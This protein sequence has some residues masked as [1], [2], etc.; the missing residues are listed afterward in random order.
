M[1]EGYGD[2]S[3]AIDSAAST[4]DQHVRG[5]E[6]A[7]DLGARAAIS[8]TAAAG[9]GFVGG[10]GGSFVM[11]GPG[12]VGGA[13]LVGGAAA[14]G[15]ERAYEGS[16]VQQWSKAL[17]RG[18]GEISYDH[19]S[20]EG[21][22][23]G[24]LNGLK[25]ALAEASSPA[26]R[27]RLQTE[28]GTVGEAFK[29]EADKNNAYFDGRG[30][31]EQGWEA[32][33]A[34]FPQLDKGDVVKAYEARLEAGKAPAE[35]VRAGYSDAVHDRVQP[36]GLPYVPEA[37]YGAYDN[38]AL[39]AAWTRYS[40]EV[41][42][43]QKGLKALEARG[44]EAS[45]M[46][47]V[48]G[49][50]SERSHHTALEAQRDEQWRDQGHVSAI[51]AEMRARGGMAPPGRSAERA[52]RAACGRQQCYRDALPAFV[53]AVTD[54]AGRQRKAGAPGRQHPRLAVGQGAGQHRVFGG[55]L[56]KRT[57]PDRD[58]PGARQQRWPDPIRPSRRP[59]AERRHPGR[60]PG[61]QHTGG[62]I[63]GAHGPTGSAATAAS[64]LSTARSAGSARA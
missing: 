5:A 14:Y 30:Q 46:P 9:G 35:A 54:A 7:T 49:W 60:P 12:T 25:E 44:P 59:H 24:Q 16:R 28:L 3:Q 33:S 42:T 47:L 56:R 36:R 51:E 61:G 26:E 29:T 15:A 45:R 48:G 23:L 11:P 50:L 62:R 58:Q 21:R 20:K 38:K 55:A 32:M 37:D 31:I 2:F 1:Y 40:G 17:G 43:D 8:G 19:F 39:Q 4:R 22:L 52:E 10:A 27:Q 53:A 41:A 6:A 63:G 64:D 13:V 34:R 18:F 57:R